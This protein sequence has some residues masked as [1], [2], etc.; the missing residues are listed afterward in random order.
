MENN[1]EEYNN[2]VHCFID[3]QEVPLKECDLEHQHK[4][5]EQPSKDVSGSEEPQNQIPMNKIPKG[6]SIISIIVKDGLIIEKT[7]ITSNGERITIQGK[8]I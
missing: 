1:E 4:E 5:V 2:E 7:Y 8:E 3:E 6:S